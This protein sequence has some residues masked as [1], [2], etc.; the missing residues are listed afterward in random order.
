MQP[1]IAN[2]LQISVSL[3]PQGPDLIDQSGKAG[4]EQADI[5][6][7]KMADK[8]NEGRLT[9]AQQAA[10]IEYSGA[11]KFDGRTFEIEIGLAALKKTLA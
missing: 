10:A 8:I 6:D 9:E 1:G 4:G 2:Q 3:A 11:G 7:L 5:V